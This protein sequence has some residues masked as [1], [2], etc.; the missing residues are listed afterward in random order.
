M[1]EEEIE[2]GR[3]FR[4]NAGIYFLLNGMISEMWFF[5]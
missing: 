2:I 3:W 1:C 5:F 4:F